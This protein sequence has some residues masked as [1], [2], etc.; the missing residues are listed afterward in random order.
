MLLR[1]LSLLVLALLLVPALRADP[2]SPGDR[3]ARR[4]QPF[5]RSHRPAFDVKAATDAYLATVPPDKKA[6]SNASF[7]GGHPRLTP[8]QQGS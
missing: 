6:R 8:K 4:A 2:Q 1:K 5:C 7:Q 3:H